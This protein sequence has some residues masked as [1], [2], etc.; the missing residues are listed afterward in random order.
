MN[1]RSELGRLGEDLA[2][3]FLTDMGWSILDRN[4]RFSREGE[5]DI[6]ATRGGVLAFVE[7][8]TRRSR[9]YGL[10]AEA[11]TFPKRRRIRSMAQRYLAERR[12]GVRAVR[13]DVIE[14]ERDARGTFAIRH[15]EDA[16]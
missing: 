16:F 11:V 7:V 13:F 2:A 9:A 5:L 14:V 10:P 8:K 12:P 15:L 1:D 6:I 3:G 4:V